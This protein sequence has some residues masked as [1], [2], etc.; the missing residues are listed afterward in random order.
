MGGPRIDVSKVNQVINAQTRVF[1]VEDIARE[2]QISIASVYGIINNMIATGAIVKD[3]KVGKRQMY[4]VSSNGSGDG[5]IKPNIALLPP[6]E[7]FE[8]VGTL[9]DMVAQG[10]SPSVMVTGLSGI[11]KT[12]LVKSRLEA[13]GLTENQDFMMVTGHASPL[14]LYRLMYEH[15]SQRLVFDD[16]DSIFREA[17][18]INLLKA[19]LDSYNVRKVSWHSSRMPDDL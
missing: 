5:A 17:D 18:S 1:A 8:Y 13:N 6:A 10:I 7:R 2:A 4:A 9:V 15:Q 11:G 14:G 12:Y 3:H 19:A 16:C